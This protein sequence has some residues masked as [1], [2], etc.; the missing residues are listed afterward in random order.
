MAIATLDVS[1]APADDARTSVEVD[2]PRHATL[3]A[4]AHVVET[5]GA[6]QRFRSRAEEYRRLQTLPPEDYSSDDELF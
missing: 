6:G 5:P 4:A 2:P 3:A 1:W